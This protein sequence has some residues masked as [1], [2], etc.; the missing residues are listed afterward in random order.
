MPLSIDVTSMA[1][2]KPLPDDAGA[3]L[4]VP[5]W[6]RFVLLAVLMYEGL[7]GLL[8]GALLVAAP[9]GEL[10]DMP[11]QIMHGTFK[12]FLIPGIIL[13]G[14]G[15]LNSAAFV[16]VVRRRNND[17][18]M[19]GL[20]LGGFFIWFVVEIIVLRTLHWLHLMWGVPI[21]AGIVTFLPLISIRHEPS[22]ATKA[23]LLCGVISSVWYFAINIFVPMQ[24]GGYNVADFTVSE[25]S[26]IGAP[27]RILWV[28]LVSPY[29]LLLA[30][31][32]WGV[33]RSSPSSK[34]LR[35]AGALII[36]Y[37]LFNLFWP[38][39]HLR[40][41]PPTLTDALHIAWASVTVLLMLL[42]MGFGAAALDRKFRI[43]TIW[44]MVLLLLFGI[45]T[46]AYAPNIPTNGPTPMIGIWERINLG[47]F[48]IW[49]VLFAL[50][51]LRVKH[52]N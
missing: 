28:L 25:L 36:A 31:L 20:G 44:S 27:T 17:W 4:M 2:T 39:M 6:S 50:K 51:I 14:L 34:K 30:G 29:P 32:G 13:F 46:S 10:M 1:K 33:L 19:A 15:I 42:M 49:I 41:T 35:I 22:R 9:D 12:D 24:Y 45:M 48:L 11:V 21:L 18:L 47:I 38:P 37:S 16:T 3:Q 7:G 40:G 5:A 23:L 43:Y 8:G 52:A 26:A